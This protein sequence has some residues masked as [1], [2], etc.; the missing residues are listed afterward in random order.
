MQE[1]E[2]EM[3]DEEQEEFEKHPLGSRYYWDESTYSSLWLNWF[4]LTIW[5]ERNVSYYLIKFITMFLII[6]SKQATRP[7]LAEIVTYWNIIYYS[8]GRMNI[9]FPGKMKEA[10]IF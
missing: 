3:E 6:L 10:K 8:D 1:K 9:F 4:I 5:F 2:Y 7:I